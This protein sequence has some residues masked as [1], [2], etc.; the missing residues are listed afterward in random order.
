[1]DEKELI[2][3]LRQ[4]QSIVQEAEIDEVFAASAFE[5]AAYHLLGGKPI[6]AA[7]AMEVA[8]RFVA[9]DEGMAINEFLL[10]LNIGSHVERSVAIA[11]YLL[12]VKKQLTFASRDIDKWY[13]LAREVKPSNFSDVVAACARRGFFVDTGEKREGLKVWQT[14][15]TG[16]A[17][18]EKELMKKD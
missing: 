1:M 2:D 7:E 12:H 9:V 13:S 11:Y 6:T 5:V 16:E 14:T 17:F 10:G 15:R 4:A 3:I 18:V 8:E